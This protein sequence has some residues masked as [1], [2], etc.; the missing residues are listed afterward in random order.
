L[1]LVSTSL[2]LLVLVGGAVAAVV[3]F[4]VFRGDDDNGRQ[5]RATPPTTTTGTT[6]TLLEPPP[7]VFR[8]DTRTPGIKR[9]SVNQDRRVVI[10]VAADRTEEVHVHGYD[11][12]SDVTPA[13][14]ARFSF[15]AREPGRFEI[16]FEG[17]GEE[18]AELSVNP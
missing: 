13:R 17:S 9:I 8:I 10:I 18:I 11:L 5:E 7:K 6:E 14:P 16:E 1:P 2:R 15:R 4:F 3:L 12:K